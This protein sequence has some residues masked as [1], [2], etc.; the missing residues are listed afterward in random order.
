MVFALVAVAGI[1]GEF[2][3]IL[4]SDRT[5]GVG[6]MAFSVAGAALGVAAVRRTGWCTTVMVMATAALLIAFASRAL[7]PAVA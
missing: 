6:D 4:A 7:E 1:L 5:F 3:Q 2:A